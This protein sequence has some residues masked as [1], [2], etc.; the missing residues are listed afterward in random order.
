MVVVERDVS[1][2]LSG[3]G[4][5]MVGLGPPGGTQVSLNSFILIFM[6]KGNPYHPIL[7]ASP[8]FS[9]THRCV[10]LHYLA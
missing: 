1:D 2:A 8:K 3:S 9:V 6:C 10:P 4:T 7:S 5:T